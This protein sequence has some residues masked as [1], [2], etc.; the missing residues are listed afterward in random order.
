M[1]IS[2][3]MNRRR[4]LQ[5]A[6]GALSGLSVGRSLGASAGVENP[7]RSRFKTRGVVLV[8]ED[9]SLRDWPGRAARAGLTTLALHHQNSPQAMVRFVESDSGRDA[10]EQCRRLGLQVE[11]EL[12]AMKELLPRELFAKEPG[13]FR[14]NDT[15]DRVG[16]GNCCVHSPR[17]LEILAE[18]AVRIGAK[19]R[20]TTGRYFLWG[21]DGAPWCRCLQCR[22]FSDSEQALIVENHLVQALRRVDGRARLAH[23][24]Y[25]NTL[26]PPR[27]VKPHPAVF[28]EYAPIH[29]RYDVPYANQTGRDARDGLSALDQNL[30]V[31]PRDTAQVLEY[32]LDVSRFSGWKRP[33]KRLPWARAVF[34]SD[35]RAYA[36]RGIRHVT[37]FAVWVD[38]DYVKNFGQP[39]FI[40]GYGEGL[41]SVK[42]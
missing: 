13:L 6:G 23:L 25:H 3:Q 5:C 42:L 32:W 17:T 14:M 11:Y 36:A 29:R 12:H 22:P 18:N 2:F 38:A 41:R 1:P 4:F 39:E 24:A 15:G 34:D 35:V 9:F 7:S 26:V 10:L 21:D 16:D 19:L 30:E 20:P 28:L 8:P 27:Q 40:A 33:A 31:F 37:S